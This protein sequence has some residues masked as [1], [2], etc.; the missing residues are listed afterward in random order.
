[1]SRQHYYMNVPVG[2][3]PPFNLEFQQDK[4]SSHVVDSQTRGAKGCSHQRIASAQGPE[5]LD[6]DIIAIQT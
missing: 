5:D 1:M 2:M 6:L 4:T 3:T